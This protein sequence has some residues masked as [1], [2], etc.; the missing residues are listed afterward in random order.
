MGRKA[1]LSTTRRRFGS[2]DLVAGCG[3]FADVYPP[4]A[5]ASGP[6]R[7]WARTSPPPTSLRRFAGRRKPAV[8]VL[9]LDQRI[10]V[11]AWQHLC[12]RGAPPREA[13]IPADPRRRA[14][15]RAR[16]RRL[17]D[18]G[19]RGARGGDRGRRLDPA[20]LRSA[21]AAS[22]V[23]FQHA[24]RVYGREGEACPEARLHEEPSVRHCPGRALH[25]QLPS[26]TRR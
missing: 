1:H 18:D 7:R 14:E 3:H 26:M 24:F 20:R 16:L 10:V 11:G 4:L 6:E 5:P 25:L 2:M 19:S 22:R 15:A 8:K 13:S 17:V 12:E 23:Y 21:W 9:L